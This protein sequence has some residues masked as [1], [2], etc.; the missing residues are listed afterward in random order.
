[1]IK[2]IPGTPF[3]VEI[4]LTASRERFAEI[5]AQDIHRQIAV[6][7]DGKVYAAPVIQRAFRRKRFRFQTTS[8]RSNKQPKS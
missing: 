8:P 2:D 6:I 4:R 7:V 3:C 5:T 1:V